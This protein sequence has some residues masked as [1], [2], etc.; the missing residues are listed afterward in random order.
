METLGN[1]LNPYSPPTSSTYLSEHPPKPS[2]ERTIP[3]IVGVPNI[4][5]KPLKGV[6]MHALWPL[7]G[8]GHIVWMGPSTVLIGL[9]KGPLVSQFSLLDLIAGFSACVVSQI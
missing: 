2:I 9:L 1:P 7:W 3:R 8:I 6:V 5:C 4:L